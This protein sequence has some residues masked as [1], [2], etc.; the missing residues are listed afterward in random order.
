M[1]R[2]YHNDIFGGL[3]REI[4]AMVGRDES[5]EQWGS[6]GATSRSERASPEAEA[7]AGTFIAKEPLGKHLPEFKTPRRGAVSAENI[8]EEGRGAR[9]QSLTAELFARSCRSDTKLTLVSALNEQFVL[10]QLITH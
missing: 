7:N 9:N 3:A 4:P 10:N 6:I 8:T 1:G 5:G 2:V